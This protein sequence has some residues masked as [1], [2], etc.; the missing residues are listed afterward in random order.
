[1]LQAHFGL[2]CRAT[3]CWQ[4]TGGAA[5]QG[6][7]EGGPHPQ[8]VGLLVLFEEGAQLNAG[9]VDLV[10]GD[11]AEADAGGVGIGQQADGQFALWWRGQVQGQRGTQCRDGVADL[12]GGRGGV[13]HRAG[14]SSPVRLGGSTPGGKR[15]SHQRCQEDTARISVTM[16][17]STTFRLP[18]RK[19]TSPATASALVAARACPLRR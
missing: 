12:V 1:M 15:S 10:A 17:A 16:N 4:V 14:G 8:H 6:Q 3:A 13:G 7:G 5:V 19:P 2:Q 18:R 11:E 9:S